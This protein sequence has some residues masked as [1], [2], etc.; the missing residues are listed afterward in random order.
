MVMKAKTKAQTNKK[1]KDQTGPV[2]VSD[3]GNCGV[4]WSD[5]GPLRTEAVKSRNLT[6]SCFRGVVSIF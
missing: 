6:G 1:S 2:G 5:D 4:N 3:V